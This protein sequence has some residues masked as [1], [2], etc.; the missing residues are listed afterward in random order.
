MVQDTIPVNVS[1][2]ATFLEMKLMK[3]IIFIKL[4]RNYITNEK[5]M[6]SYNNIHECNPSKFH[7]CE[8]VSAR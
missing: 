5:Y 7:V 6:H 2:K 3:L 1:M 4:V 8:Y